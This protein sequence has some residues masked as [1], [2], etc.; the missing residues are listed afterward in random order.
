MG[1]KEKRPRIKEMETLVEDF[2]ATFAQLAQDNFRLQGNLEK[3][4]KFYAEN[5]KEPGKRL[6]NGC[7]KRAG[8]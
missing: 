1:R 6:S 7:K 4:S 3:V 2:R 5:K 8:R